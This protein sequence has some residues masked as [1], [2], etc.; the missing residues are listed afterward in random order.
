[1]VAMRKIPSTRRRRS[2][3]S[4]TQSA[5]RTGHFPGICIC[6]NICILEIF[7][8]PPKAL[9]RPNFDVAF[10]GLSLVVFVFVF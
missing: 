6:N 7:Q 8:F 5:S 10:Q 4:T 3:S 1:M 2:S 9:V